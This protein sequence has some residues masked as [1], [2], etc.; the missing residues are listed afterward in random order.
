[1]IHVNVVVGGQTNGELSNSLFGVF[2]RWISCVF[3]RKL[4]A[5]NS[6]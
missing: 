1:M 2:D 4:T 6:P 5:I 3:E